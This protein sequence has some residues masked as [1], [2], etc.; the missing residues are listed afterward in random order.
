MNRLLA[1]IT[2]GLAV[3]TL[4][5]LPA[6]A[7][8]GHTSHGGPTQHNSRGSSPR[9][10]DRTARGR[11]P[12]GTSGGHLPGPRRGL[13]P[14]QKKALDAFMMANKGTLSGPQQAALNRLL[15]GE[16]LSS[17][18]RTTLA[19][20]LASDDQLDPEVRE[21]ISQGLKDDL[22]AKKLNGKPQVVRL[23]KVKN[24]TGL[25]LEV[26]VQYRTQKEPEKWAWFP[27]NP[28][29]STRALSFLL[30]PGETIDPRDGGQQV[31]ASRVRVWARSLSSDRKWLEYKDHDLWLVPEVDQDEH[32]YYAPAIEGFAFTFTP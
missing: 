31:N 20:L 27:A 4:V 17:D 3:F 5:T 7:Q 24:A 12:S 19:G 22:E 15:S 13:T 25:P 2:A 32:R 11:S 21:A 28:G 8:H 1:Q 30:K 16:D 23:L 18:D 9:G 14:R 6:S 26:S 10:A 29:P